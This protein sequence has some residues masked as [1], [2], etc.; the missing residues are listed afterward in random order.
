MKKQ[1]EITARTREKL[2]DAFWELYCANGMGKV[3]V[4]AVA[5]AAGFNRS[6]FYEY[7]TDIYEL[8][9]ELENALIQD[10]KEQISCE[11]SD[12]FPKK[13]LEFSKVCAKIFSGHDD[14]IYILLSDKGDPAFLPKLKA[15]LLPVILRNF[16]FSKE[17][18]Y[19]DYLMT[20]AFSSLIGMLNHWYAKGKE[21]STEELFQVT[22]SLVAGGISGF[23]KKQIFEQE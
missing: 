1:P 15:M 12:G 20:F 19:L 17:E 23:T 16:G 2:M 6:T 18:P 7:F 22:Q 3:T 10:L 8:L 21:I 14:M 11:F 9:E 13:F 4:G 5:K